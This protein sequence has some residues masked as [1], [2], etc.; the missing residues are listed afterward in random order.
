MSRESEEKNG[1]QVD[2]K[3]AA[4]E[5]AL[6]ATAASR[7]HLSVSLYARLTTGCRPY[8]VAG[9]QVTQQNRA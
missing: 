8:G 6:E 1:Q 3:R 7:S 4:R 5:L 9:P 2:I